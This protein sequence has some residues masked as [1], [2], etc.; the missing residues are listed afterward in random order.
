MD[1]VEHGFH[2]SFTEAMLSGVRSLRVV[3]EHPSVEVL[4]KPFDRRIDFLSESDV[5]KLVFDGAVESFTYPVSLRTFR[6]DLCV[7]YILDGQI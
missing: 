1:A 3:I 5:V 4:L 7:I 6:L 2:G